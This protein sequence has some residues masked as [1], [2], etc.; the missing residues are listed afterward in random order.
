MACG[1]C[2]SKF[3]EKLELD[4]PAE[5][6]GNNVLCK[7]CGLI[8]HYPPASQEQMKKFYENCYVDE[9][10]D[11]ASTC[12]DLAKNRIEVLSHY[13][14][15]KKLSPALEIGCARGEFL[16]ELSK[17]GVDVEGVEPSKGLSCYAVNNYDVKVTNGFYDE[18]EEKIDYYGLISLFH[19]LEHFDKPVDILRRIRRELREDGYLYL[20][21]PTLADCQLATVFKVMHPITFVVDTLSAML[22]MTGFRPLFIEERG[23]HLRVL[24]VPMEECKDLLFSES[25][26]VVE[27][28]NAYLKGRREVKRKIHDKLEALRGISCGAIYGAGNNTVN[29]LREFPFEE[30]DIIDV[31][32]GDKAKKGREFAKWTVRSDEELFNWRGNYVIISSYAFQTEI[33]HKLQY[34]EQ[35]GIKLI[36][37]YE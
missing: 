22:Q 30:L 36:K 27:K 10:A 5:R 11:S 3:Y 32:D 26:T 21:V 2:G 7:S 34:L 19:V 35:F 28:V 25:H 13:V 29:L 31:F 16:A 12:F 1:L 24:A 20:E 17:C 33:Y 18:L 4:E 6:V 15:L 14:D 9:Y 37:L 8:Y 23:Y